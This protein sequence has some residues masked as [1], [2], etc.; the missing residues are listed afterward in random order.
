MRSSRASNS[1]GGR[2]LQKR[3][4]RSAIWD[5]ARAIA[6]AFTL[7]IELLRVLQT[8]DWG[9]ARIFPA[10][11]IQVGGRCKFLV[12][13]GEWGVGSVQCLVG[14]WSSVVIQTDNH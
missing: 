6:S 10:E 7:S 12:G 5:F 13:S 11:K 8:R 14:Q 4:I 1:S 2:F 9:P 3:A